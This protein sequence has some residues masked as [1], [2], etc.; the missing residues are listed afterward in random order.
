VSNEREV[1]RAGYDAIAECYRAWSSA[2]WPTTEWVRKLLDLL[3]EPS[4]VLE[5]GC[6]NG[7]PAGRLIADRHE[8]T[9]VDISSAQL[10]LARTAVPMGSFVQADYTRFDPG[11]PIDALV[12]ILTVTHV[13]RNEHAA[14][15]ERFASWLRPGGFLLATFGTADLEDSFEDD[16]LG[17]PMFFSHFD[18]DTN[19]RLVREAGFKLLEH[20]VV[21]MFEEGHGEVR[22]LWVIAQLG[23]RA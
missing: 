17:A 6:G 23:S 7:I 13:P 21:P 19:R 15:L 5:V 9:G 11:G 16:W 1:V 12:A 18:A 8:Y 20:E 22:F 4:V 14:V 10:D 3:A 2:G